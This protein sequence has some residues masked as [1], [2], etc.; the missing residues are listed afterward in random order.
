M[1]KD[2]KD[3]YGGKEQLKQCFPIYLRM[4]FFL[5]FCSIISVSAVHSAN[6]F[7]VSKIEVHC[8]T[9]IGRKLVL[10]R[11]PIVVG[12]S[13]SDN[14]LDDSVK[15][16]YSTGYF[17][18]VKIK[19]IDSTLFIDLVENKIING[20]VFIGNDNVK[21]THLERLVRSRP[22][23]VYDKGIVSSDVVRIKQAYAS[24]G[25]L[26][27]SVDVQAN[28]VS[29]TMVSLVYTIQEGVK[30]KINT[31]SFVGNKAYS[32]TRL[33]RIISTKKS[34]YFS[35]G[36]VD[37]YNENKLRFD[38]NAIRQFYY[39]RGYA[40]IKVSSQAI[41]DTKK[42]LYDL[43][44]KIDEGGIY[45]VGNVTI[46][47][48]LEE[49]Q[50]EKL[51]RLIQAK[52]GAVY[53]PQWIEK[54]INNISKYF[55][56][57][58]KSFVR[59][60]SRINRDVAQGIVDVEYL[61]DQD[62]PVYIARI[63]IEGNDVSHDFV[64]RRE[65]GFSEG[66]PINAMMIERAKRR[67]KNTGFFSEVNVFQLPTDVPDRVVLK[68]H[69]KQLSS[70][71]I[72][73]SLSYGSNK[74]F[75]NLEG[76]F[77]DNN[78]FGR[79]YKQS[80][81]LSLINK[82]Y[83]FENPYFF[84]SRIAAG[85]DLGQSNLTESFGNVDK[86]LHSA[87]IMLPITETISATYSY[88][89]RLLQYQSA[90]DKKVSS[91]YKSLINGKKFITHS[92]SQHFVYSTL[93]NQIMPREGLMMVSSYDYGGFGG[94]SRYHRIGWKSSLFHLLSDNLD[95]IGSLKFGYGYIIPTNKY[96]QIF[97]QF[98]IDTDDLRGFA[99]KGI[100]PRVD[101]DAIGGKISLSANAAISFPMP[102][103]PPSIGLRGSFFVDSA[104]LYGNNFP[105]RTFGGNLEG[106]EGFLRISTGAE[107]SWNLPFVT[108]GVYYGIPL[109]KKSYDKSM[110]IGF[111]IGNAAR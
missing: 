3:S 59:V 41:L 4:G 2:K 107:I 65:L 64:I 93:D 36:G 16:L 84:G 82:A 23:T 54:T 30:T 89:Y 81:A 80:I 78:L 87:H 96:L 33:E 51:L 62:S 94:Y 24:I 71:S 79:G 49:A 88:S 26:N 75:P 106:S 56:S 42:N 61:L 99:D 1:G 108:A 52:S 9:D 68:V 95:I 103:I 13:F 69:V 72:S 92:I 83:S 34:G 11:I 6:A 25:Y 15:L 19:V 37:I 21:N 105:W 47:S 10:S 29:P 35:F 66:D 20:L 38:E 14:D 28:V 70:T 18:D 48:S 76:Y 8:A 77:S 12:K 101:G 22:A 91:V 5:L 27:V 74:N 104:N 46:R 39:N 44:F 67:I 57:I 110:Y 55:L 32:N 31:I 98:S 7:S 85:F 97:D 43:I 109:R 63:E 45:R 17:S 111:Y 50:D 90:P 100:G 102:F 53:N 86:Q 58:G 40:G 73:I 60:D